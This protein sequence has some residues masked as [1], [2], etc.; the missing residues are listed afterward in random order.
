MERIEAS[1]ADIPRIIRE[2]AKGGWYVLIVDGH[3][4]KVYRLW[5]Q[6][7]ERPD[8]VRASGSMFHKSQRAFVAELAEFMGA[9][10]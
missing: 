1:R 4:F 8:G 3:T 2:R 7:M 10:S 5:A 6:V 9:A